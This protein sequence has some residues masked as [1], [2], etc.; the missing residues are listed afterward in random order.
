[1]T[2][3][4]A[5]AIAERKAITKFGIPVIYNS[6]TKTAQ[7]DQNYQ[8]VNALGAIETV[9]DTLLVIAA[10]FSGI[11]HGSV[12]TIGGVSKKVYA[13]RDEGVSTKRLLL[14]NA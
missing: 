2:I 14:R 6:A 11:A 3:R 10:D 4:D 12:I 5:V 7:Y 1:M 8:M 9:E 13:I